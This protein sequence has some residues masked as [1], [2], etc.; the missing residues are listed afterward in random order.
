[1]EAVQAQVRTITDELNTLR[2]EIIAIKGSHAVLHQT[3]VEANAGH[4]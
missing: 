4:N 3:A 2:N 1:M